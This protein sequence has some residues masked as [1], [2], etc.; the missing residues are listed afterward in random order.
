MRRIAF[1]KALDSN[2]QPWSV[3]HWVRFST[4]QRELWDNELCYA[5]LSRAMTYLVARMMRG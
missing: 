3:R 5:Q 1:V 4:A 2:P